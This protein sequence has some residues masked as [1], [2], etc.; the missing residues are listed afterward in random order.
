[1]VHP[2]SEAHLFTDFLIAMLNKP[3]PMSVHD[4]KILRTEFHKWRKMLNQSR[5]TQNALP[6][7]PFAD[8]LQGY[9]SEAGGVK[10]VSNTFTF[11]A[12]QF[13]VIETCEHVHLHARTLIVF[14]FVTGMCY[15]SL[16][17]VTVD[18]IQF[19]EHNQIQIT[20]LSRKRGHRSSTPGNFTRPLSP[21]LYTFFS[22]HLLNTI[23]TQLPTLL[24]GGFKKSLTTLKTYLVQS[25]IHAIIIEK[26][27]WHGLRRGFVASC[28]DLGV[29]DRNIATT[30]C[31]KENFLTSYRRA[32]AVTDADIHYNGCLRTPALLS[33]VRTRFDPRVL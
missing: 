33:I 31:I 5:S 30:L 18:P 17:G 3:Q 28:K 25:G 20:L 14:C 23:R 1:S 19:L 8:A 32:A 2:Q 7:V 27:K 29:P 16:T 22:R 12:A 24:P 10:D 15:N 26:M 4:S 13:A 11:I 6:L 21:E 9:R